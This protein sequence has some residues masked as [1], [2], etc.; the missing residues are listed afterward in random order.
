[1]VR[2]VRDEGKYRAFLNGKKT[3]YAGSA[4]DVKMLVERATEA[5][6]EFE[7]KQKVTVTLAGP[8]KD[9]LNSGSEL[10]AE[11]V[12]LDPPE[13]VVAGEN[14]LDVHSG[15]RPPPN[16]EAYAEELYEQARNYA[17]NR[18]HVVLTDI[19]V[20]LESCARKCAELDRRLRPEP[21]LTLER[22]VDVLHKIVA[23][24]L[25]REIIEELHQHEGSIF[26]LAAGFLEAKLKE[27]DD[28]RER[29]EVDGRQ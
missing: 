14:S 2:W 15:R 23:P 5:V 27:K 9:E 24:H 19:Y 13:R 18:K 25:L 22:F 6:E 20:A 16:M 28:E 21:V 17:A 1:M 10:I 26:V 29:R 3:V 7:R 4:P 11:M 8:E 12:E